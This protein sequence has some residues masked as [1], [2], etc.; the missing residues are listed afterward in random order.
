MIY[1]LTTFENFK[2]Q[3]L[4]LHSNTDEYDC[5]R[6]YEKYLQC[7]IER[8]ALVFE[9]EFQT[10]AEYLDRLCLTRVFSG[11]CESLKWCGKRNYETLKHY[12]SAL[13]G[14]AKMLRAGEEILKTQHSDNAY[15]GH[16]VNFICS[17]IL[18]IYECIKVEFK[19]LSEAESNI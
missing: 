17:E 19:K 6:A 3:F 13:V 2:E 12:V 11:V 9:N 7:Y 8:Y 18:S 16:K 4:K 5:C 1:E 15:F 10:I 14:A